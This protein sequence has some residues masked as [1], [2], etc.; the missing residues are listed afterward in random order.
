MNDYLQALEN[1]VLAAKVTAHVRE[2]IEENARLRA[3]L[4]QLEW[5]GVRE[6]CQ[7]C[8]NIRAVGHASDCELAALLKEAA[9]A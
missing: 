7:V 8:G 9:D 4:R 1:A 3:M 5:A 6:N 2:L